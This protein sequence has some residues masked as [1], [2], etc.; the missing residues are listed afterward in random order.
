MAESD[1]FCARRRVIDF[2]KNAARV[3]EKQFSGL[4]YFHAAWKTVKKPKTNFLLQILDL[5]R[6]R[7]L[8][9]AQASRCPPIMFLL[10]DSYEISEMSQFH[11]DT[12]SVSV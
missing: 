8:S 1:S 10:A 5:A 3:V 6:E 11:T 4:T 7:G 12:L 9:Q 2:L